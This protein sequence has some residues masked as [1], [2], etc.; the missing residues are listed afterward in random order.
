MEFS[1]FDADNDNKQSGNYAALL[2][3]G[4]WWNSNVRQNINGPYSRPYSYQTIGWKRHH[5]LKTSQ[6]MIRPAA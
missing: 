1:T 4:F 2:G 3:G 5:N 6:M